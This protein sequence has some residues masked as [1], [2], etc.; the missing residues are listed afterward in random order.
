M[1]ERKGRE[2]EGAIGKEG[3]EKQ[4]ESGGFVARMPDSLILRFCR[5]DL[6]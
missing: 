1:T 3:E 2:Q 4:R 6:G 5:A